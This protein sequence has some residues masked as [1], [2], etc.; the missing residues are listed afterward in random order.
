MVKKI[1]GMSGVCAKITK[2]WQCNSG[3]QICTWD[4]EKVGGCV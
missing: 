4:E 1:E 2:K 3:S